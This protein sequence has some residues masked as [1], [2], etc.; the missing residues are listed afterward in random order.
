MV[1]QNL[2][3]LLQVGDLQKKVEKAEG[4]GKRQRDVLEKLNEETNMVKFKNQL[5]IEM[6]SLTANHAS[7]FVLVAFMLVTFVFM[8]VAMA[9]WCFGSWRSRSWTS[10]TRR[11]I[12]RWS[13]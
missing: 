5:L 13:G 4:E 6:V 1:C 2:T 12:W 8:T 9:M 3:S 7:E 10:S 11:R